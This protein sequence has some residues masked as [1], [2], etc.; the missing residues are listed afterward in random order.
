MR[1]NNQ[2]LALYFV[3]VTFLIKS[4][5]KFINKREHIIYVFNNHK[6]FKSR[7]D[8]KFKQTKWKKLISSK[9]HLTFK[10]NNGEEAIHILDCR[11]GISIA[12]IA[13]N[14]L[15]SS[16]QYKYYDQIHW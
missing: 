16:M 10:L 6:N 2:N 12:I 8:D 13:I 4:A 5:Q 9:L 7:N 15:T 14:K 11:E 3:M 1:F